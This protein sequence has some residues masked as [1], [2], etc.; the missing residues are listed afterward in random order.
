[1]RDQAAL[2]D[3]ARRAAGYVAPVESNLAGG[4]FDQPA[5][6][7]EKR[8]FAMPVGTE[9][10]DVLVLT[11]RERQAVQDLMVAIS[12]RQAFDFKKRV[13]GSLALRDRR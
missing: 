8:R 4:R 2:N 10:T 7:L 5:D 12:R 9:E 6:C 3:V 11:H 13:H 1:M